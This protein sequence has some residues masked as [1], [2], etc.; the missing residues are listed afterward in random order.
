LKLVRC[1][2]SLGATLAALR[3]ISETHFL[4]C[5]SAA[6][7]AL[8]R[9]L[10]GLTGHVAHPIHSIQATGINVYVS[11]KDIEVTGPANPNAEHSGLEEVG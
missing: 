7:A 1:P 6:P 9:Y 11:D 10:A 3:S 4:D 5:T 2:R 8:D